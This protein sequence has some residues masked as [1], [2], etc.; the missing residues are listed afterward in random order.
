MGIITSIESTRKNDNRKNIFVDEKCVCS[1]S[2]FCVFKNK[3][4]QD[5]EITEEQLQTMQIESD[6]EMFFPK[7]VKMQTKNMKTTKQVKDYLE[8]QGLLQQTIHIVLGKLDEYK[9]V[10]DEVYAKRYLERYKKSKGIQKIKYE[11]RQ[12][13]VE[14]EIIDRVLGAVS[15]QCEEVW[16][17]SIK[18]MKNKQANYEN[19]TKLVRYLTSKGFGM[20]D[21]RVVLQRLRK[22]EDD[23]NWE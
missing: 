21:I 3:L 19:Y 17:L 8:Q 9:Y 12:K 4:R 23:E 14:D 22:G 13:G 20:E 16:E 2:E 1:L 11:L 15:N 5:M 6:V 18:Y 7:I 10:N